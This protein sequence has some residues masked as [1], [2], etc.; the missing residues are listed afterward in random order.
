MST[1][2]I[3]PSGHRRLARAFVPTFALTLA[4]ADAVNAAEAVKRNRTNVGR[5]PTEVAV[6]VVN[7]SYEDAKAEL[8]AAIEGRSLKI[9]RVARVN[10]MLERTG[11][12][13]GS[14]K[15][16]YSEAEVVEFCS[17][18]LTRKL[19]EA[20]PHNLVHCP[21]QIAVYGISGEEGRSYY[22]LKKLPARGEL[23]AIEKLLHEIAR[24][25]AQ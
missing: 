17:A 14:T 15:K 1:S 24:E 13:V 16:V 18:A 12:D 2:R 3:A 4:L 22:A 9:D 23:Q 11:A 20:N 8:I 21:Y 19:V 6:Y 5:V 25:A 7:A 10:E